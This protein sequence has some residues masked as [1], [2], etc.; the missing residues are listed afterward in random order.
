ML[1]IDKEC[2][3]N[4]TKYKHICNGN[5]G[6]TELEILLFDVHGRA[7]DKTTKQLYYV[8]FCPYC[9]IEIDKEDRPYLKHEVDYK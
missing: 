7:F 9:G 8:K 4:E 3:G 1:I 6:K 5:N 2:S